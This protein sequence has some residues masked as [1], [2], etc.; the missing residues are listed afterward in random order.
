MQFSR[1]GGPATPEDHVYRVVT[2]WKSRQAF[3]NWRRK[4]SRERPSRGERDAS[5][6]AGP[7]MVTTYDTIG[8]NNERSSG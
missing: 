1:T 2:R 8:A 3:E 7:A 4:E 5:V 6:F